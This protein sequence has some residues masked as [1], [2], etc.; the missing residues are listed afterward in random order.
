MKISPEALLSFKEHVLEEYPREAVGVLQNDKYLRCSNTANNSTTNFILSA[1][2]L[3]SIRQN[4]PIQAVLHSH[5]YDPMNPPLVEAHWP[6]HQDMVAW[7]E[8]SIPWGIVS[9]DGVGISQILWLDDEPKDLLDR[10]FIHGVSDCYSLV[11]DY[12]AQKL[13]IRLKNYPRGWDWWHSGEDHYLKNFQ[14]AGFVE[15][16]RKDARVHDVLLYKIQSP[17][18]CHASV[19]TGKDTILHHLVRRKSC[20]QAR[21]MWQRF[22]VLAVRHER[23]A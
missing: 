13:N 12:Y 7:L 19:I 15:I 5:P 1:T 14:D 22:E 3:L 8:D 11:R 6:S 21:S 20:V 4:G 10:Q 17:V 2:E 16:P 18:V 9:T 23:F